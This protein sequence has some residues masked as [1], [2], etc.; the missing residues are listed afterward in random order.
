M[1]WKS[2]DEA[3]YGQL[4]QQVYTYLYPLWF[5]DCDDVPWHMTWR[6]RNLRRDIRVGGRRR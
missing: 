1:P 6:L 5:W 3:R 4:A 2:D